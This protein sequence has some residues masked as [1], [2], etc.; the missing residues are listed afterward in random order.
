M[1]KSILNFPKLKFNFKWLW[2]I[3]AIQFFLAAISILKFE[4]SQTNTG[5][6]GYSPQRLILFSFTTLIGIIILIVSNKIISEIEQRIDAILKKNYSSFSIFSLT[7]FFI[8]LVIFLIPPIA[9]GEYWFYF[10]HLQPLLI[11]LILFPLQLTF[12]KIF[13]N[14][15]WPQKRISLIPWIITFILFSIWIF[16]SKSKYGITP[17]THFW[18][19]LGIPLTSYQ[20]LVI[21]LISIISTYLISLIKKPEKLIFSKIDIIIAILLYLTTIIVWLNTPMNKH[22]FSLEPTYPYFQAFP[23]SDAQ[24]HDL[25]AESII[26]GWGINFGNMTG[27]PLYIAILAVLKLISNNNLKFQAFFQISILSI[28]IPILYFFGKHFFSEFFGLALS[29]VILFKQRNAIVLSSIVAGVNPKLFMSENF[30]LMSLII[31]SGMLFL[32]NRNKNRKNWFPVINGAILGLSCLLRPNP[33]LLVPFIL[34]FMLL[35]NWKNKNLWVFQSISFVV[36][37][38]IF[39]SPWLFIGKSPSGTPF[40]F[41]KINNLIEK[42]YSYSELSETNSEFQSLQLIYKGFSKIANPI[43][44]SSD[45][46]VPPIDL[47]KFPDFVFNHTIH[48]FIGGFLTLPDSFHIEDQNLIQ[49]VQRIYWL[50]GEN[51]K[52]TGQ[53]DNDQAL[54]IGI[55]IIIFSFGLFHSWKE[56][57]WGG[58]TPFLI[59]L[60]YCLS[61]GFARNSGSRYL[62][63]IDWVIYFYYILGLIYIINFFF[64]GLLNEK[65]IKTN[66]ELDMPIERTQDNK[67]LKIL[68]STILIGLFLLIPISSIKN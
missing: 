2:K 41:N 8:S 39:F 13:K 32:W 68:L 10:Q 23:Y 14:K 60:V 4:Q 48:N 49:L 36:G 43:I 62:V 21:F 24:I 47:Q 3:G 12:Y 30:T 56:W 44:N 38:I 53:L 34:L 25:G 54:F 20:F 61:L 50:D 37:F 65:N 33:L 11:V 29:L 42:R 51:E 9:L 35:A 18:N 1:K 5:I 63:P 16:I 66:L 40:I 22:Y 52:W 46:Q 45:N 55:N 64:N 26:N 15:K 57:K 17:D 67:Y 7:L 19:V 27:K 28:I 31:F 6:F 58:L 59:F